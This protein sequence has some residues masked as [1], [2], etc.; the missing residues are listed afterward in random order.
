MRLSFSSMPT[1]RVNIPKAVM[2]SVLFLTITALGGCSTS[3]IQTSLR[4]G[5]G[6]GGTNLLNYPK[7]YDFYKAPH[8]FRNASPGTVVRLQFVGDAGGYTTL[9]VMYHS[10]DSQ[11]KDALVTGLVT[12][13]D[14][15]PKI[16]KWPVISWD[17]G[18][19]GM[20]QAC[21]PSRMGMGGI[22]PNLGIR[23]VYVA[24]D[25][26]GLGI[27]GKIHPYLNR[28]IEA[29]S[30]IDIVR[31]VQEI[32]DAHAG[33]AWVAVGDSQGGH[34]VL[35]TG[36]IAPKYAPE[37]SLKGVVAV[38]P[39]VLLGQTFQG[40]SP[41]LIQLIETMVVFGYKASDPA[42]NLGSIMTPA[43]LSLYSTIKTGCV[44][45]I[46][47]AF[48]KAYQNSKGKIFKVPP[49]QTALG[50]DWLSLNNEP[51]VKT[52]SPILVIG[53]GQD[54]IAVPARIDALMPKLCELGD[55]ASIGWYPT[56]GHGNELNLALAQVKAWVLNRFAGK[57]VKPECPY[58][59]PTWLK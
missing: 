40:D 37:L 4:P 32:P 49:L 53:G 3:A 14:A 57:P 44:D 15:K 55:N 16:G 51:Q 45:Q 10:T 43:G 25:Y 26:L 46:A 58:S 34:A 7:G 41:E 23:A 36:E 1:L 12:Y 20:S 39:G 47:V 38:A 13:P 28:T 52:Q 11:G 24:T 59:P 6:V 17:H 31:A 8:G 19:I 35:A 9:R 22:A 33:N 5:N 18:T 42:L 27:D 50:K 30:T 21:A 2:L 54:A 56:G 29:N 48:I